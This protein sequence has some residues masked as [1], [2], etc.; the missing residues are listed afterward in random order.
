MTMWTSSIILGQVIIL[1]ICCSDTLRKSTQNSFQYKAKE[2]RL[3]QHN[4]QFN[5]NEGGNNG[6]QFIGSSFGKNSTPIIREII[7]SKQYALRP[8]KNNFE[9]KVSEEV[10][11][12][13][14]F[15]SKEHHF[16]SEKK[17]VA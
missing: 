2:A 6:H 7:R 10:K 1:E 8:N 5:K 9:H 4:L 17:E 13:D 15:E 11:L 3:S 16:S 14:S 12:D